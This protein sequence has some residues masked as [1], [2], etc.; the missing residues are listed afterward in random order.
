[1]VEPLANDLS[2]GVHDDGANAWV[3]VTERPSRRKL[4]RTTHQDGIELVLW[5]GD[6]TVGHV[7]P[8]L[9]GSNFGRAPGRER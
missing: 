2:T 1:L 3:G 9:L 4:E 5:R 7:L 8:L 6:F